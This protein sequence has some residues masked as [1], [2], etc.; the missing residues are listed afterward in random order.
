MKVSRVRTIGLPSGIRC[1][2][3]EEADIT[4]AL[5]VPANLVIVTDIINKYLRQKD[6]LV[7]FRDDLITTLTD[8]IKFP[9]LVETVKED[10]KDVTV[11]AEKPG[12][13]LD[14]MVVA[15]VK[16]EFTHPKFPVSGADNKAKE[17]SVYSALQAI[18]DTL[19]DVDEKGAAVA[20][21]PKSGRLL[22]PGF[23]YKL[24]I[25][26]PERKPGKA[27][28][29]PDYAVEAAQNIINNKS[30]AKW[31]EKFTKGFVDANKVTIDPISFESFVTVPKPGATAQEV[32]ACR[33]LNI[34]NLAWAIAEK[35][36]QVREKTKAKK[37]AEFA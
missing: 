4:K 9:M 15:L 35:E 18:A 14:R 23:A 22:A 32:E 21:D 33:A 30:E 10:G 5:T 11:P 3:Y 20:R 6:A 37:L 29:P 1:L 24:D 27:K 28:T 8:V 36:A 19:G 31:A 25:A 12:E 13:Y 34:T 7:D 16:G 26:R 2:Q 17:A